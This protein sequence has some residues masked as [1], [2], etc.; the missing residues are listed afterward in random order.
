MKVTCRSRIVDTVLASSRPV[1]VEARVVI[2]SCRAQR[3]YFC[4]CMRFEYSILAMSALT[5]PPSVHTV[6]IFMLQSRG[7]TP[8]LYCDFHGHSR[9]KMVFI[10]GCSA[11]SDV[12]TFPKTLSTEAPQ[13]SYKSS[14]FTV[15]D[16]KEGSA[17]VAIFKEYGVV[18]SY[19]MESTFAGYAPRRLIPFFGHTLAAV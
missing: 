5:P 10:Y 11:D 3:A 4:T 17:R 13:F 15:T 18:R 6:Q 19:T 9:R 1:D 14:R 16:D 7:I 2:S 12:T 8:E